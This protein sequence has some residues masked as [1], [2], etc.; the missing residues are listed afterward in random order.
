MEAGGEVSTKR[1][2]GIWGGVEGGASSA[3]AV[4]ERRES[5]QCHKCHQF[6]IR[7]VERLPWGLTGECLHKRCTNCKVEYYDDGLTW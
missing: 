2:G 3:S 5:K 6:A 4:A 7:V 1:A